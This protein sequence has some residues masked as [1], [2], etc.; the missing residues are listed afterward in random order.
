MR[1]QFMQIRWEIK[2]VICLCL[3]LIGCTTPK[4]VS[5]KSLATVQQPRA[6]WLGTNEFGCKIYTNTLRH[7]LTTNCPFTNE[8]VLLFKYTNDVSKKQL[9]LQQSTDMINWKDVQVFKAGTPTNYC[10]VRRTNEHMFFR[11]KVN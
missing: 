5:Q 2:V 9:T 1:S 8:I 10:D 11:M 7:V 6:I 3:L 4:L